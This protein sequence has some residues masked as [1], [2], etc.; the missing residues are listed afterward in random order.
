MSFK[1]PRLICSLILF[2]LFP[3][4][5]PL[6][7]TCALCSK[8]QRTAWSLIQHVQTAHGI[9]CC[10]RSASQQPDMEADQ[11]AD[12][13]TASETRTSTPLPGP[14]PSWSTSSGSPKSLASPIP[15]AHSPSP[16][17]AYSLAHSPAHSLAHSP[18]HPLSSI[19]PPGLAYPLLPGLDPYYRYLQMPPPPY[20]LSSGVQHHQLSDRRLF[21]SLDHQPTRRDDQLGS[22]RS[23]PHLFLPNP[24]E[25]LQ[26]VGRSNGLTA[27]REERSFKR[28]SSGDSLGDR[29]RR[30]ESALTAIHSAAPSEVAEDLSVKQLMAISDKAEQKVEQN[31]P[32]S[33]SSLVGELMQRFGFNDISEYKEAYR[34]ALQESTKEIK[35]EM[36]S[37]LQKEERKEED[38]KEEIDC[39]KEPSIHETA[40]AQFAGFWNPASYSTGPVKPDG[41]TLGRGKKNGGTK[42]LNLQLPPGI[43][44]PLI[45]PSAVRALAQKGRLDAIFDPELRKEII[46]RGRNDTCEFCGKV[47]KN[48]SNLTVHRRSH[49]GEKPYKCEMCP[50]SCAQSSKLTRHM[51]THGRTGKDVMKCSLCQMPFSLPSTLEKHMRKCP[52]SGNT[53]GSIT[54]SASLLCRDPVQAIQENSLNLS[55]QSEIA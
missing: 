11:P 5:E 7:L 52:G 1:R 13:T 15:S 6:S 46:S 8:S 55:K 3:P 40:S 10:Y 35:C 49:T 53:V 19:L 4:S 37:V 14:P 48:C 29:K 28:R 25:E 54:W 36:D 30:R 16:S 12:L 51:K 21:P 18:A 34:R 44:L 32:L 47:F 24:F 38:A 33:Q 26:N 41:R 22:F 42:D 39:H 31:S 17:P 27:H 2:S 23:N 9:Q 20:R 43:T 50:Y 45:E